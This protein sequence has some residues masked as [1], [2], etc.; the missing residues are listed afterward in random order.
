MT[1]RSFDVITPHDSNIIGPTSGL[2]IAVAGNLVVID[3]NDVTKTI[4]V[5]ANC[6]L[7][8]NVKIIKNT[9]TTATGILALR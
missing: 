3:W 2:Y 7:P 9:N 5:G 6:H 8:I 4:A 1:T